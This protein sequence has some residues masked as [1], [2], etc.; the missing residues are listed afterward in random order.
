MTRNKKFILFTII[1]FGI[2]GYA[3]FGIP[4][5]NINKIL[6]QQL[7]SIP[8]AGV[9]QLRL[10]VGS[11]LDQINYSCL[12]SDIV[13]TV[14]PSVTPTPT[15]IPSSTAVP[16][17]TSTPTRTPTPTPTR[18]VTPTYPGNGTTANTASGPVPRD[19]A[20]TQAEVAI[21]SNKDSDCWIILYGIVYDVS[22]Q[23][24][25]NTTNWS[26]GSSH[27]N[28]FRDNT[29]GK[30]L[31]DDLINSGDG[32]GF[33]SESKHFSSGTFKDRVK[34]QMAELKIGHI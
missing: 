12:R 10:R 3:L 29:C 25:N 31:T 18:T 15:P 5:D 17:P 4:T 27:H 33:S 7:S 21:H 16:T 14:T 28:R 26:G 22:P 1:I 11:P 8:I 30:N 9:T 13:I 2:W 24:T 20:Y 32:N 34:I 23:V 19:Q 6:A